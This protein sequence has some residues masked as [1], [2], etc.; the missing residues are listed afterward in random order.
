MDHSKK[1]TVP[2]QSVAAIPRNILRHRMFSVGQGGNWFPAADVYETASA[3][4]VQIDISGMNPQALSV[5]ADGTKITVS[6]ERGYSPQEMVSAIH[7]LE[8]EHGF[9]ERSISLPKAVDVAK[10]VS[11]TKN[12]FL[13]I[14][15]PLRRNP[16]KIKIP[17][18]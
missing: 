7:Q 8:I 17:V 9:F 15:L 16:G 4:I 12:G 6:G 3:I 14:T 5:L 18:R 11:E 10:A 1:K 13:Q 2:S